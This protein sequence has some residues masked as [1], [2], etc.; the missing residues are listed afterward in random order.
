MINASIFCRS[1]ITCI[2]IVSGFS[3]LIIQTGDRDE[4]RIVK[5]LDV[6]IT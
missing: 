5:W 1:N 3:V 2:T 4:N 6:Y